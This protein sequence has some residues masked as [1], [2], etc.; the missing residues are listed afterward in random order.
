MLRGGAWNNQQNN[1]RCAARNQNNPN[2]R[3]NNIGVRVVVSHIFLP[4]AGN[5]TGWPSGG[6]VV[7]AIIKKWRGLSAPQEQSPH[8][9]FPGGRLAG[10]ARCGTGQI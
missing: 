2:N 10:A 3:N 6:C 8:K 1:A 9:R 7:E 5:T 4:P